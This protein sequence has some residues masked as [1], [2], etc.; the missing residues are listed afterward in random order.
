MKLFILTHRLFL[1]LFWNCFDVIYYAY[2]DLFAQILSVYMQDHVLDLNL[3]RSEL[4]SHFGTAICRGLYCEKVPKKLAH[5]LCVKQSSI[6]GIGC[7]FL[8]SP[9]S[10]RFFRSS[11]ERYVYGLIR[12]VVEKCTWHVGKCR[13]D[14]DN[15]EARLTHIILDSHYPS[16][17]S[18]SNDLYYCRLPK[19][20]VLSNGGSLL[21]KIQS[22]SGK[23]L[24]AN[25]QAFVVDRI[26]PNRNSEPP[27]TAA[28]IKQRN[29]YHFYHDGIPQHL[30]LFPEA[31]QTI[32]GLLRAHI[33]GQQHTLLVGPAGIGRVTLDHALHIFL[34]QNVVLFIMLPNTFV[35]ITMSVFIL[36]LFIDL[37]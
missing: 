26:T 14:E 22:C 15:K 12:G 3:L 20:A 13:R 28:G 18:K 11:V 25:I 33:F 4:W 36:S 7:N 5:S 10:G 19:S 35:P 17:S 2:C 34:V 31:L 16:K 29:P 1:L 30:T 23:K 9:K 32:I 8:V 6:T 27:A 37:S 24:S 21:R